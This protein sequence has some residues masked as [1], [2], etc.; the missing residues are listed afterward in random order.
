V[1]RAFAEAHGLADP[2]RLVVIV[3]EWVANI[4]EHGRPPP[5]SLVVLCLEAAEA[6][7][8]RLSFSDAGIAFDPR[9]AGDEGP[10]EE[11]GGG[12]GIALIRAWCEIESYARRGGRNRLVLRLKS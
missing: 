2:D 11:R 9:D 1:A 8:V 3:E 10:N 5:D 7:T 4:V 6:G 12:A